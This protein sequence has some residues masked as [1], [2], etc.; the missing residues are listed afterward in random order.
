LKIDV[1]DDSSIDDSDT[2]LDDLVPKIKHNPV[3]LDMKK[4]RSDNR[5]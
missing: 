1:E 3:K 4:I 5:Q 2:E